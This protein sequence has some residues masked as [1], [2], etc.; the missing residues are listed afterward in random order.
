MEVLFGDNESAI[1]IMDRQLVD[2]VLGLH[3]TRMAHLKI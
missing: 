2:T 3:I 1:E